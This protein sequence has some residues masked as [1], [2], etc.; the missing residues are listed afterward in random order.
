MPAALPFT[1]EL[2]A[3]TAVVCGA[4]ATRERLGRAPL[5]VLL[6]TRVGIHSGTA[7][8]GNIGTG[9]RNNWRKIPGAAAKTVA[10]KRFRGVSFSMPKCR[11]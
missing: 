1:L 6:G 7:D 4:H 11:G 3:L 9:P 5:F 10:S 8:A 2:L